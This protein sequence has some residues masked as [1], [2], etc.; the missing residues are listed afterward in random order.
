MNMS[1]KNNVEKK[2]KEIEPKFLVNRFNG[3]F[4]T[5]AEVTEALHQAV[6]E[7]FS[8]EDQEVRREQLRLYKDLVKNTLGHDIDINPERDP[9]FSVAGVPIEKVYLEKYNLLS[10]NEDDSQNNF[11]L[12]PTTLLLSGDYFAEMSEHGQ[13]FF[14]EGDKKHI[15][16]NFFD[17]VIVNEKRDWIMQFGFSNF[18]EAGKNFEFSEGS[19]VFEPEV[20]N[21]IKDSPQSG[22]IAKKLQEMLTWFNHDLT[23]HG[24]F[25]PSD[26]N[27][28]ARITLSSKKSGHLHDTFRNFDI[29]NEDTFGSAFAGELWSLNLHES[30]FQ[31]FVAERPAILRYLRMHVDKY[32][33]SV[34]GAVSPVHDAELSNDIKEYLLK[35]YAFGFFRLVNPADYATNPEFEAIR[36][37]YPNLAD[38]GPKED[39]VRKFTFGTEGLVKQDRKT[40]IPHSEVFSAFSGSFENVAVMKEFMA[41]LVGHFNEGEK[42]S[43]EDEQKI[44]PYLK[45][46][47]GKALFTFLMDTLNIPVNIEFGNR[48]YEE[49]VTFFEKNSGEVVNCLFEE[50]TTAKNFS[51]RIIKNVYGFLAPKI[52]RIHF[53]KGRDDRKS[54]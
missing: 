4:K 35:A 24:T 21:T 7:I 10:F 26:R 52:G 14:E 20:L 23:A 42:M 39:H 37:R 47:S 48:T 11:I 1:P 45:Q 28:D 6:E 8:H 51:K 50:G 29:A 43:K 46:M 30:I 2:G 49:K 18:K 44:R 25:L 15:D 9:F 12:P 13:K 36:A 17:P 3:M 19:F 38:L 34:E 22:D 32:A 27:A 5:N 33:R 53:E 54:K 16:F 41:K 40:F 31:E